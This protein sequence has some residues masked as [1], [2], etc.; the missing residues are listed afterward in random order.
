[1]SPYG[2]KETK[3]MSPQ[4]DKETTPFRGVSMSPC[5]R[6]EADTTGHVRVCPVCPGEKR[7]FPF[8]LD[9][10]DCSTFSPITHPQNSRNR[11]TLNLVH[12]PRSIAVL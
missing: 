7:L 5:G 12:I 8:P 2:D 3:A 6:R 4:G 10:S 11:E 9:R 1:M